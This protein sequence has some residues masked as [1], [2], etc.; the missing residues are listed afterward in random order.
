MATSDFDYGGGTA[1]GKI[2]DLD[3]T[4]DIQFPDMQT[5][6][7]E[8][9]PPTGSGLA[10]ITLVANGVDDNGNATGVGLPNEANLGVLTDVVNGETFINNVGTVFDDQAPRS[11][12]DGSATTPWIGN[13]QPEAGSLG[14]VDGLTPAQ[15]AGKWTLQVVDETNNGSNDILEGF[16]KGFSLH[17]SSLIST[18]GFGANAD[19]G[20]DNP[21]YSTTNDHSRTV[22]LVTT[23]KINGVTTVV[24]PGALGGSPSNV[25]STNEST[26]G[27]TAGGS[28]GTGPGIVAA[29]DN[30]LGA[31]S[32]Y[33]GRL[34]IA[35]VGL[36]DVGAPATDTGIFLVHS[37]NDGGNWNDTTQ[38]PPIQ[39]NDDT[40]ADNFSEG[41]RPEFMP[42]IA[43]DPITGT[44]VI[45]YYD[46]RY[47]ASELRVANSI[48]YSV[49]GGADF[50]TSVT[51]NQETTATDAITGATVDVAPI[52]GNQGQAGTLGFGDRQGL[53]VYDGDVIP[54]FSSNLNSGGV[55]IMTADVTIPSGPTVVS[56]DMGPV[57]SDFTY[58]PTVYSDSSG[59][60]YAPI[61][62]NN[63]FATASDAPYP[64]GTR[65]LSSFVISFDR[66]VDISTFTTS[67][68]QVMYE[69][70]TGATSTVAVAS[71]TPLDNRTEF[72][73]DLVGLGLLATQFLI[74]LV[75][76]QFAVGTY[77]YA[78]G[79]PASTPDGALVSDDIRSVPTGIADDAGPTGT[80]TVSGS[81]ETILLGTSQ[82]TVFAV[83]NPVLGTPFQAPYNS[84]TLPLIIPGPHVVSTAVV[85]AGTYNTTT[86]YTTTTPSSRATSRTCRT[87]TTSTSA[88]PSTTSAPQPRARRP[89]ST[90]T[91]QLLLPITDAFQI[92]QDATDQI[93]VN[94]NLA[95]AAGDDLE[96]QLVAQ[97]GNT[98]TLLNGTVA[99][100][101][102][103]FNDY[104]PT[105]TVAPVTPLSALVNDNTAGDWRLVITNKGSSTASLTV[106]DWSLQLPHTTSDNEVLN[107]TATGI[108]VT[109]D[110]NMMMTGAN[111]LTAAAVLQMIGPLGAITG[112][113]TIING[114][115]LYSEGLIP[116]ALEN[117]VFEITFPTQSLNGTYTLSIAPSVEDTNG[118]AVD[119]NLNAGLDVLEGT[120][121]TNTVV[122]ST[123]YP[124]SQAVTLPPTSTVTSTISI[125]DAFTIAQPTDTWTLTS[126]LTTASTQLTVGADT[127]TPP[128]GQFTVTIDNEQLLIAANTTGTTWNIVQRGVDGTMPA[129]HN[130]G[131][132]II[133]TGNQIQLQLD[134]TPPSGSTLKASDLQAQLISPIGTVI[135][136]FTNVGQGDGGVQ[137]FNFTTFD[138]FATTPIQ[139]ATPPFAST[140]NPQQPLSVLDGQSTAGTW[141]LVITNDQH[142]LDRHRHSGQLVADVPA[143]DAGHR[144][145]ARGRDRRRRPDQRRLPHLQRRSDQRGRLGAVDGGRTGG[146]QQQRQHRPRQR[147]RRRPVGP[148]GQHG[149][150]GLGQRRPVEDHRLPDHQPRRADLRPAHQPGADRRPQHQQHRRL[151]PEQRPR[152]VRHLRADGQ[153]QQRHDSRE[154][155]RLQRQRGRHRPA[156]I[157]RRRPDL[158]DPR[159]LDQRLHQHQRRH[160]HVGPARIPT[161]T[162]CRRWTRPPPPPAPRNYLF[163]G[164]VGYQVTVDPTPLNG[165]IV[166]YAAFSNGTAITTG[167]ANPNGG[168]Y[169]S[170]DGGNTWALIQSGNATSVALAAGSGDAYNDSNRNLETLYAGFAGKG[171]YYHPEC[172]GRG[173]G[174]PHATQ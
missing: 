14:E 130:A 132:D 64:V 12:V 41:D 43:V 89:A 96:I 103:A 72:G 91:G 104:A 158:A 127:P 163:V 140:Y 71:I 88:A 93:Q 59:P 146:R 139:N 90:T 47:D 51:M 44:V 118:N 115:T 37:D 52:P 148:V 11:I 111:T 35:Y 65:G 174:R 45:D 9:I 3:V 170:E 33:E 83:P 99:S 166:V 162:P 19:T 6:Q 62:Y 102:L 137:E 101:T 120:N 95:N 39:V 38:N 129:S 57:V 31:L 7:I 152:P 13:F 119:T 173:H 15:V 125:S 75:A 121:P 117:R 40:P 27:T 30:T 168:L 160:G 28:P 1:F 76:P 29:I 141:Q 63:V 78:V 108:L 128:P 124:N 149:L 164:L 135:Q 67:Q 42:S 157:R 46:G 156:P 26:S 82:N 85:S 165:Q 70:T 126:P 123:T 98:V 159:Q 54:L 56:G 24:S 109:F 49:D 74:T 110:R 84:T 25:Y 68:I 153:P 79:L 167:A 138:D 134:I 105:G 86:T 50:S 66:P 23:R 8:L 147:H 77:S 151:R 133:Y 112:P 87:K 114:Q 122:V 150:R 100:N 48:S 69:S 10:T 116:L 55:E 144:P 169:R 80:A 154:H 131:A 97:D 171:V 142:H 58:Q 2:D 20:T 17:F 18:S 16:I 5:L 32:P 73:P 107:S 136:L 145:G 53:V 161:A 34:Y 61:T 21:S 155:R 22:S 172:H 4:V 106:A 36:A 113:F 94:L 92:R 81:S 143:R 60:N